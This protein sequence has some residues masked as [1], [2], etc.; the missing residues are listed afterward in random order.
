ME[1]ANEIVSRLEDLARLQRARV[2]KMINKAGS[3]HTGGSL[4]ITDI[5]TALYFH[6]MKY[7]SNNPKWKERDRFVLSKGHA[8][9]ALYTALVEA[10]FIP[11]EDLYT[12]R[13][14]RSKLQGHPDVKTP[15]VE[16]SSGSLGQGMAAAVGMALGCRLD[17]LKNTIY[18]L[19]GDGECQEGIIWESAQAAAHYELDNIIG[20]L[21]RNRLQ[22]DGPTEAVMRLEPLA[23]RWRA[24]GW[25]VLEI[26]GH[27][28]KE[29]IDAVE[30]AKI[31]PKKPVMILCN[32]IKGK[33]VEATENNNFYHGR[34]LTDEQLEVAFKELGFPGGIE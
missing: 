34:P 5:L 23:D 28:I 12:L 4:S 18:F 29:I 30:S 13:E 31:V 26:N 16:I 24:F 2:L 8:A 33:G 27:S 17:N 14:F 20:F 11:K 9:P 21:D 10:G 15:G 3:G 7:D 25:K 6:I 1:E 22:I 19:V 32:T